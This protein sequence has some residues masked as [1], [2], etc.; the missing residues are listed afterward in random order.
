MTPSPG[1]HLAFNGSLLHGAPSILAPGGRSSASNSH[2]SREIHFQDKN[3]CNYR[4]T[5]LVNIWLN[6][7][8]AGV[9]PL[10]EEIV[11]ALTG[12][13]MST[14]NGFASSPMQ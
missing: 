13:C 12:S 6:H 4:V 9:K 11:A 8:P 2:T 10:S 7:S 14:Y 1:K 5:F 3:T